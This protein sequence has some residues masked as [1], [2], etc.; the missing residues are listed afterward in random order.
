MEVKGGTWLVD[1]GLNLNAKAFRALAKAEYEIGALRKHGD[2]RCEIYPSHMTDEHLKFLEWVRA[3]YAGVGLQSFDADVL[4]GV[5]RPFSEDRFNK[6]VEEVAAIVPDI[7]IEIILGIPGDNPDTFKRTMEKALKL[8]VS[9]RVFHCLV[10]PGALMTRAPASFEMNFD[11]FTLQMISCKGWSKDDL[12]KTRRWL[13]DN[14]ESEDKDIPH[15]GTWKFPRFKRVEG[16][17]TTSER[18]LSQNVLEHP[19]ANR[20]RPHEIDSGV[21]TAA[22]VLPPVPAALHDVVRRHVAQV[23]PWTLR[24]AQQLDIEI[25]NGIALTIDRPEGAFVLKIGRQESLPSH[26]RA[27]NGIAYS[28]E[29][30]GKE[31]S[32]QFDNF[33]PLD[34][35][36]QRLHP[37]MRAVIFGMQLKGAQKKPAGNG[38]LAVIQDRAPA[39]S[40][41]APQAIAK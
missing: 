18:G 13:D 25:A 38:S 17:K 14:G 3:R 29:S 16:W 2:F 23:L 20:G 15:A 37:I 31:G 19:F 21:P 4:K 34:R 8:P 12:E 10:L 30:A 5:E 40:G 26:F 6:V 7:T 1:P 9:I 28:Y 35:L 11:P 24:S 32:S 36:I 27:A 39:A 22:P 33:E 41:T